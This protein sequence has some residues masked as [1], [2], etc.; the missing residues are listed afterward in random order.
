MKNDQREPGF[1]P[2]AWFSTNK[3]IVGLWALPAEDVV[4]W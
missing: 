2:T 3:I 1:L 4:E